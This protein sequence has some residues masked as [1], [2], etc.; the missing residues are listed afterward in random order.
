MSKYV[1]NPTHFAAECV[2]QDGHCRIA[3]ENIL[4]LDDGK[5]HI[6]IEHLQRRCGS[7]VIIHDASDKRQSLLYHTSCERMTDVVH[8][9]FQDHL[10]APASLPQPAS[11]MSLGELHR[12]CV[13][14]S[15]EDCKAKVQGFS[16]KSVSQE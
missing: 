9:I 15:Y 7:V 5:E 14:I 16:F 10:G 8:Q 2:R 1:Q 11:E 6:A 4:F 3:R 13:S 12:R